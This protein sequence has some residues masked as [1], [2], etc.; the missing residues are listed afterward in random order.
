VTSEGNAVG[1]LQKGHARRVDIS[2]PAG[3]VASLQAG[4]PTAR[5]VLLVPGYTGSKEDFGPILDPLAAAGLHAVAIDLP[6]QLDSPGPDDPAAYTPAELADTLCAVAA[7]FDQPVLL[8]GHSFGGLVARAAVLGTP[9]LFASLV[10]LCSG[11]AAIGGQ[12]K[13]TMDALDPVLEAGG[14]PAVYAAMQASW[15]AEPGWVAP[16]PELAAFLEHRFLTSSPAMLRGMAE[17]IRTEPDRVA[18]LAAVDLPVLVAHGA[19]DDAWPP[20]VQR[21]MADR[22]GARYAIIPNAAHSPAVENPPATVDVLL[23]FWG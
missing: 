10:L 22:L 8:L 21:E 20:A 19:D 5:P 13:A 23:D 1:Q 12:R 11:P 4:E 6:G 16:P 17:A 9:E 2:L 7:A 3:R 18:D 15:L 14:L